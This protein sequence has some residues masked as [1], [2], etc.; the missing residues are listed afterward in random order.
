MV[1]ELPLIGCLAARMPGE[2][3]VTG[4]RELRV[5]E[6]DRIATLVSNLRAIGAD[7]DEL[8]DGFV[9]RGKSGP[10]KGRVQTHADHRIAMAF[11]MLGAL[12]GNDIELDDPACVAVSF[13]DFWTELRRVSAL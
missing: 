3:R 6:S 13:P 4:A 9:V 7:A 2:S 1:D 10:L 12:P 8:P 5:K 11:G